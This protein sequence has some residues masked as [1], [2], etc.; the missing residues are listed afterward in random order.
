MVS[1]VRHSDSS[2]GLLILDRSMYIS[3]RC[4]SF[5]DGFSKSFHS[6]VLE[7]SMFLKNNTS[8]MSVVPSKIPILSRYSTWVYIYM[9]PQSKL[10]S[11]P[12]SLRKVESYIGLC[13]FL[14]L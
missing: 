12:P 11:R 6:C 4:N 2:I 7:P 8:P 9:P 14:C 3:K 5:L 10:Q 1:I 13:V